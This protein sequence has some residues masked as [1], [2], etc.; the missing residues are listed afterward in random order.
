MEQRIIT[1][2]EKKLI[3]KSLRMTLAKNKTFELWQSFMLQRKKITNN[4]TTDLIS[5]QIF[6]GS[7]DFR[8]FN[9]NTEFEKW[10]AVEVLDFNLIPDRMKTHTLGGGLYAVFIHKGVASDCNKT[11]QFIF[12]SWLPNSDYELDKRE[13]F[14]LLGNKY[15]N[16]DPDSEEEVWIPIK[17][18][19]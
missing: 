13:H 8:D 10:A 12:K 7:L 15:K 14:E 4:L 16:D 5:M 18:K 2:P 3:G 19:K 1:L 9:L 6:D 17:R 11:F